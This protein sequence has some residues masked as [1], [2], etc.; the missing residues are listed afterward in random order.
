MRR[1]AL[2]LAVLAWMPVPAGALDIP[3][4]PSSCGMQI[5]RGD[6]GVLQGDLDCTGEPGP[7]AVTLGP[8]ARLLLNGHRITGAR[9]HDVSCEA[10]V[11]ARTCVIEGPGELTGSRYGLFTSERARVENVVIHGNDVGI[12]SSYG[13]VSHASRLDLTGVVIRDNTGDGVRGGTKLYATD[14]TIENNGGVGTTSWGP[15]RLVRTTITG[16]GSTGI[17][18]GRYHDFYELYFYTRHQL[19]LVDSTV[20]GNG[21]GDGSGDLLS[22]RK[23]RLLRTTCGTSGNP[24][25][26]GTPTWGVCTGD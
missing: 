17:V 14:T 3:G 9:V 11:P 25:V 16:N 19:V 22:G 24:T 23:P 15:S 1:L 26:A 12:Y 7:S 18:T 6:P 8:G 21:L 5:S 10:A 2:V 20:T 13:D 4:D